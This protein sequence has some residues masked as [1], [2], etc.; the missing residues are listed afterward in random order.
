MFRETHTLDEPLLTA[1]ELSV[2]LGDIPAKTILQYARQGRLPC[3]RVGRHV[4]FVKS[5]VE[6]ALDTQRESRLVTNR[7]G[8]RAAPSVGRTAR[9]RRVPRGG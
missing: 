3:V 8:T 5:D 4:R 9:V 2:L 6:L 1:K 7:P